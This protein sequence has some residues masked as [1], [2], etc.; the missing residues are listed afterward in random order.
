MGS[1]GAASYP[2]PQVEAYLA[3]TVDKMRSELRGILA[4]SVQA[5]SA[6][7]RDAWL[8]DWPS[9]VVLVGCWE[10]DWAWPVAGRSGMHLQGCNA[11]LTVRWPVA[12]TP[13]HEKGCRCLRP[14]PAALPA[15]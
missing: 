5:Y 1:H 3:A 6:K 11:A 9:Q 2:S 13:G 8:F 4:D 14:G 12:A 7:P 10:R 15:A